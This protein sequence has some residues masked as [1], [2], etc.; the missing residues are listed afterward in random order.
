MAGLDH[1]DHV[2]LSTL[3]R[4][5]RSSLQ[6][7]ASQLGIARATV[8]ER[9]KK[10]TQSGILQGFHA[11]I[12]WSKLGFT[13]VAWVALQT[14]Q[15]GEAYNVLDDLLAIPEVDAA[16]MVTGRF[17]CLVKIWAQSHE[18]LQKVLF[19][20]IGHIRGFRRA[21][22]MVVLSTPLDN[23][24]PQ[25]LDILNTLE[26]PHSEPPDSDPKNS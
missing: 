2:I 6:D 9:V 24:T 17:D 15:G 26:A 20:Q 5:A 19:D 25:L 1:I 14:E 13:V 11:R 21:E 23:H 12:D 8:H 3:S 18:S 22:T 10:L 16:Y 4:N 7:I